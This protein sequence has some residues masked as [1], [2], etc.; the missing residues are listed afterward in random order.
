MS[1]PDSN[2]TSL[3]S[4]RMGSFTSAPKILNPDSADDAVTFPA[5]V[6]TPAEMETFCRQ[7]LRSLPPLL[8]RDLAAIEPPADPENQIRIMQWNMLSQ[9]ESVGL[10]AYLVFFFA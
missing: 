8:T 3:F 7:Q 1:H 6:M 4:V 2:L 9:S 10:A 5:D